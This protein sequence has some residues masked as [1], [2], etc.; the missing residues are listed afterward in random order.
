[1]KKYY[2]SQLKRNPFKLNDMDGKKNLAHQN[3]FTIL[4]IPSGLFKKWSLMKGVNFWS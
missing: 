3:K 2:L 1:M 4:E